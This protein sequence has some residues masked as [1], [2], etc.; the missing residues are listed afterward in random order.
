MKNP[1][2]KTPASSLKPD[3]VRELADRIHRLEA[4]VAYLK[5]RLVVHPPPIPPLPQPSGPP[6]LPWHPYQEP[7]CR[8]KIWW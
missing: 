4:E 5:G 7:Y 3:T 6:Y 2:R 1:K 8:P